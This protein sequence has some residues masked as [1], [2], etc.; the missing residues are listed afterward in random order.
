MTYTLERT[1]T[2]AKWLSKIKDK[3]MRYRIEARLTRVVSGNFGDHKQLEPQL[4]ELRFF[5]GSGYRIYYSIKGNTIVLLLNGG[6][7]STQQQDI[8]NA[9]TLLN[10]LEN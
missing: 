5:F 10:E 7:K 6:D 2:F 9:K 4:F 8:D 1:A 3:K